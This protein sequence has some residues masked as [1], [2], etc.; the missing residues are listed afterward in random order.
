ISFSRTVS[1]IGS[2]RLTPLNIGLKTPTSSPF[3]RKTP[4]IPPPT[5]VLPIPVSVPVM[6]NPFPF[7]PF[8][9]TLID[10][11]LYRCYRGFSISRYM[12]NCLFHNTNHFFNVLVCTRKSGHKYDIISS[13][14]SNHPALTHF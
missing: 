1:L 13:W 7:I 10:Y 11:L 8:P 14:T 3:F 12:L 6:N 2:F 5:N 9:P 4:A